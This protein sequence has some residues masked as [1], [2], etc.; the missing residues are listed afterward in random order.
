MNRVIEAVRSNVP[1][2][3]W[4]ELRRRLEGDDEPAEPPE[5]EDDEAF[6]PDDDRSC[7]SHPSPTTI[8][9]SWKTDGPA[10]GLQ[11]IG[12]SRSVGAVE[13]VA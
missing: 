7:S 1:E 10:S 9:T 12:G 5:E 8:S 13:R 3:M 6:E 11:A 2:S 4:P